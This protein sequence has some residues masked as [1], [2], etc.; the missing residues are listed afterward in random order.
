MALKE[1]NA[2]GCGCKLDIY[3][4]TYTCIT[5]THQN[6]GKQT[7][8]PSPVGGT[9][10]EGR[11]FCDQDTSLS[12]LASRLRTVTTPTY[13]MVEKCLPYIHLWEFLCVLR[14]AQMFQRKTAHHQFK[15][16]DYAYDFIDERASFGMILTFR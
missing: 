8:Y 10:N 9:R 4:Y 3:I 16:S 1:A 15:D 13:T 6:G 12:Q 7:T 11:Y 14:H 5:Y 2:K